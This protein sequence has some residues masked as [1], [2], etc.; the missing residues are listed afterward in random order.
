MNVRCTSIFTDCSI[1]SWP[2][3]LETGDMR[4]AHGRFGHHLSTHRP[5]IRKE[6]PLS[7]ATISPTYQPGGAAQVRRSAAAIY[8]RNAPYG[9]LPTP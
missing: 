4:P 1:W 7:H 2:V 6:V 5:I 9:Q 3:H 8:I